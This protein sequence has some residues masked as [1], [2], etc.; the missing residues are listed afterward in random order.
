M[1]KKV[2]LIKIKPA[3]LLE[4]ILT[5]MDLA[6]LKNMI[7]KLT[8]LHESKCLDQIQEKGTK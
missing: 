8:A 7:E 6:T 1:R 4:N 2:N 3:L 5:K